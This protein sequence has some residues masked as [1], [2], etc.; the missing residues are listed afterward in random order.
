MTLADNRPIVLINSGAYVAQELMAEFG[1]LPPAFLPVGLQCLYELQVRMMEELD[2]VVYLTVPESF[3]ASAWDVDRLAALGLNVIAT[4]DAMSLGAALLYALGQIGF[5]NCPLRIL[6]GDTLIWG[7][8]VR[9]DDVA[10]V[11]A[12]A[13][14]Y[15]WA[16]VA[17][18]DE[19]RIGTITL[20]EVAETGLR[21]C[22]YFAFA[23]AA[24][25]AE[26]LAVSSGDFYEALNRHAASTRLTGITPGRWLDFGHVQTFF[27]S[28]RV[29]TTERAFNS[30][31]I[32]ELKVRKRSS[33][34]A[35][36][37]Q[38]EARWLREVPPSLAPFC[39]RVL[40]AGEDGGSFYYDSE[41]EY[42][43]TLSELHVFGRVKPQ[44]WARILASCTAFLDGSVKAAQFK[45]EG[46]PG[47]LRRLVV[48]KTASRLEH[49]SETTG[50]DLDAP[51]TLNGVSTPSLRQCLRDIE[52]VLQDCGDAP[53]V[54]HGDLCFSNMLFDFRTDRVRVI[55]PRALTDDG[56]FSLYGDCRYDAAK[57]MH[58]IC[59]RY[60]MIVA[61]HYVGG[62]VGANDFALEF[63]LE[64][65]HTELEDA[66]QLLTM[67]GVQ[68]GSAVVWAAMT[69]LFLSMPPLHDDRPDRQVAFIAN[70]LRLHQGLEHAA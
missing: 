1:D 7:I 38:A 17:L 27:R 57:L 31:E 54:M 3:R 29:V 35:A 22:G 19:D 55:D 69:S 34:A 2:A 45:N 4:P 48:D 37:L 9:R 21:V 44:A 63:P 51:N 39:A 68:L 36:K 16:H 59:G 56:T 18:D 41:Y 5:R 30:L 13:D 10:A 24:R 11:A 61:G 32:S 12:G 53:S 49:F 58:S 62:R 66:V 20:P 15:R 47:L 28:R 14:G 67:G 42:M 70:A 25:F 64:P 40:D 6:H 52:A 60:D 33:V 8:D 26:A 46:S 23:S 65:W 50:F 43:P